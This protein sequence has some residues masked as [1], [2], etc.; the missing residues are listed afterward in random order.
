MT[1]L[2]I[3][4]SPEHV[5]CRY[6]VRAFAPAFE[7]AGIPLR[8]EALRTGAGRLAQLN[9]AGR[10]DF[11]LLQR[12]LLP[13]WQLALLRRRARRLIF[14]FDD[15][16]LYRDSYD[17]RGPECPRRA[18]R[19]ARTVGRAD[20]VIAGNAFLADC[21]RRAGAEP[22]RVR[23]IPTCIETR[24]VVPAPPRAAATE[25]PGLT[26]AWIGSSSTLNGLE[27]E[28]DLLSSLGRSVPGLTLRLICDRFANFDPLPIER[29]PWS[30][31]IED[32]ALSTADAGISL[33][34]DDL[35]SRGKCG[36]KV[37]QYL[38]CG[39]PVVASPVGVHPEMIEPGVNGFLP[40]NEAE[41]IA[42]IRQLVAEPKRRQAMGAAARSAAV[43]RYSVDAW[44][45][46]FVAAVSGSH[47]PATTRLEASH[48]RPHRPSPAVKAPGPT[49]QPLPG[50]RRR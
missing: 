37:L 33:V 34:P 44:S 49:P 10:Y 17:P 39:L 5:C 2:A 22:D 7:A 38:A 18:A 29:V 3:V 30:E 27:R 15:A 43:Q 12:K 20:L 42:A 26:L 48:A 9:G 24:L 19:F 6:R 4:E 8:I 46:P 1:G 35:W 11:V 25:R 21:A 50:P 16:I 13:G 31:A 45:G 23:V 40:R 41:W 14:D 36:L 32:E 28:R 47:G